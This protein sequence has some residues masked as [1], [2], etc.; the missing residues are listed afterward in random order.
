LI[1][2]YA[3]WLE[4]T[5]RRR[6]GGFIKEVDEREEGLIRKA[7]STGRPLTGGGF[8]RRLEE[9][10]QRRLIPKPPGRLKKEAK[11]M[12]SVLSFPSFPIDLYYGRIG[13][14]NF[15]SSIY[16]STEEGASAGMN[17]LRGGVIPAIFKQESSAEVVISSIIPS[18]DT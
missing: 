9:R 11:N 10:V 18:L 15:L 1:P 8:V 5:E 14:I 7:T 13:R 16:T 6:Y 3:D 12:G 17:I 4:E 2:R